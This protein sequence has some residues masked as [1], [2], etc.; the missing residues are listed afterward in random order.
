MSR[1]PFG[2]STTHRPTRPHRT[3]PQVVIVGANFAGLT[4]A[5]HLSAA[6]A[7]T[8][9]DSSPWFEWL[10]NIHELL[11]G[12]KQPATLRLPRADLIAAAGH[13]FRRGRVDRIDPQGR[14]IHLVGGRS[15]G[16]DACVVAVGGINET[17]GVPGAGRHALPFKSVAECAAIGQ[18]LAAL[19]RRPGA[20]SVVIVGGG[21][22]GVE[23]LGEIL[24][25]YRTRP[26]LHIRVIE[27]ASRLLPGTP[28]RLDAV[29]R[30]HCSPF[31]VRFDTATRVTR[32]TPT[33]VHLSSG[34]VV[35]ADLTIWTG[36]VCAPPLLVASGLAD[37]PQQ[38]A[39]VRPTLQSRRFDHIVVVGDA[40]AFPKPLSKQA[41][42]AMQMGAHAADT[43]TRLLRGA[44]PRAFQPT[45]K[46]M[47]VAFGDLDTFLVADGL[48][49]A[50]PSL[51]L[52]KEAIFQLTMAQIDR[53]TG[54]P[55][56]ARLGGR[57]TRA[58]G[59]L[60]RP[61]VTSP[62]QLW[63]LGHLRMLR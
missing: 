49:V 8:V 5:Q 57:V 45:A 43:V 4:A 53:P 17:F 48:A 16:F 19:G 37:R 31:A 12:V 14:R 41:Y 61:T 21:L 36:G 47:L 6:H 63:R 7:V 62:S 38:W 15:L 29:I 35:R 59:A 2:A 56:L 51:A 58:L 44:T 54:R 10:P 34:E 25:R 28:P 33:R 3:P 27:A 40:A 52:L 39:A 20:V 23:A 9:I 1:G 22:E 30:R 18:R 11:S 60:V 46:P 32:V 50:S 42:Y 26:H 55:A 13:R 24:R